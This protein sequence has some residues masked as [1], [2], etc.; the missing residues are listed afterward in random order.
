MTTNW[1]NLARRHTREGLKQALP[2]PVV[3]AH[4]GIRLEPQGDRLVA[5][6]PF[7]DDSSPSFAVFRLDDDTLR[8]GCWA[9][10][11]G[12]GDI[13]DVIRAARGCSFPEA[14]NLAGEMLDQDPPEVP[15][16]PEVDRE[17]RDFSQELELG[18]GRAAVEELLAAKMLDVSVDWLM[19]EWQVH[20]VRDEVRIPHRD[21]EGEVLA[22][23]RRSE[24]MDWVPMALTGSRLSAFYGAWRDKGRAQVVLC[25]GESDTWAVSWWLR[26]EAVDV[27]GL[28]SGVS[29]RPRS[30]WLAHLD[31]R[32]VTLLFDA[33]DAG[34]AGARRWAE[35]I[36]DARVA[37]V[38]EGLDACKAGKDA[39]LEA[40]AQARAV[41][42]MSAA[43]LQPQGDRYWSGV[44]GQNPRPV[45]D[46]LMELVEVVDLPDQTV[47]RVRVPSRT[48]PV[49][50]PSTTF[51]GQSLQ[52]W[53]N[54]LDLSWSGGPKDAQVLLEL[55]K[56]DALFVPR[57]EGT[58][59]AGW[60]DGSF[61]LP[62]GTIGQ[63]GASYVPPEADVG[64]AGFLAVR[65]GP[66]DREVPKLLAE[67]H[68]SDVVRPIVGWTAAAPLRSLCQQFPP[69]AVVGGSGWGKTTLVAEVL[70]CFGFWTKTPV[71]LTATTPHGVASFA[72]ATN[73]TPVWFDEY[74]H[75]ARV[76]TR[77]ALDQVLR[78]AWDG[79][80][81]I[82]G[83]LS[84][85]RQKITRLPAL[86]PIVVSG[87]D[88]FTETSHAER[89]AIVAMPREGRR[90]DVLDRLQAAQVAGFGAAYLAWL[91]DQHARGELLAPPRLRVRP[92]QARAVVAWGYRLLAEFCEVVCGYRLPDY[93]GSR[94]E[95]AHQEAAESSPYEEA[96]REFYDVTDRNMDPIVWADGDDL[97]VRLRPLAQA[98]ERESS[99]VW[100]GGEKAA[101]A[102]Y[103]ERFGLDDGRSRAGRYVRLHGARAELSLGDETGT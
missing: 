39:T 68:A 18:Q 8:A 66:W 81:A 79:S 13:F 30:E 5:R 64:L 3:C 77:L 92:D 33:D 4:L 37:R 22:L 2:L 15:E 28:P 60:V 103:T 59:V 56:Q 29:A 84:D 75:G 89:M 58:R 97:L 41:E 51:A 9:C 26:H 16:L 6:C 86:A 100:P 43:P 36:A 67:L 95:A 34:R 78:D 61:V 21:G 32:E 57:R 80:A 1:S 27:L 10:D 7:H 91:V 31:G 38:P 17:P 96:L 52:R 93:D 94:L 71:T 102:W 42:D 83:G 99:I 45:S 23:K 24:R 98:V 50:L 47:Y 82:K 73:A 101:R 87:E 76:D 46:F 11:F 53:S 55:L 14:M 54:A 63:S 90:P 48:E 25:E 70:R 85:N 72:Q 35:A 40:L 65:A 49:D 20:G 69:L 62:G 74:R 88:A 12:P 19:R 44:G